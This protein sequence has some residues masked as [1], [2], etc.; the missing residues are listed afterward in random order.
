MGKVVTVPEDYSA[1]L[2]GSL[3]VTEVLRDHILWR[4]WGGVV[5]LSFLCT[6]ACLVLHPS[7]LHHR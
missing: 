6:G 3:K 5:L 2:P 7:R 4:G 1:L